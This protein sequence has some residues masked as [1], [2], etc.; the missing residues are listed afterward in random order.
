MK[1]I[2]PEISWPS[3]LI[4]ERVVAVDYQNAFVQ[5]CG[6]HSIHELKIVVGLK[7]NGFVGI[8]AD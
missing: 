3:T 1:M 7:P 8:D 6:E 2:A 4:F 5:I